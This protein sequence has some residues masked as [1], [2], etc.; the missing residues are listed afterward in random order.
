MLAGDWL[1]FLQAFVMLFAIFDP[2]G[3]LPI[4][5]SLTIDFSE[6]E[7]RRVAAQSSLVAFFILIVFAYGGFYLLNLLRITINDFKIVSGIILLIFAVEYVLGREKRYVREGKPEE[8][9]VF[10]MATPLL[11]GPGSISVVMLT[12]NPPFGPL[13]TLTIIILNVV[14]AWIVLGLGAKLRGLLG[15]QGAAVISR[16]MGLITGAIAVGFIRD[17]VAGILQEL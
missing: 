12:V 6:A 9:A 3:S 2:I 15:Y 7:R 13:T 14:I 4:F 1:S 5:F 8:I 10:P 16:I 17:G 11:A